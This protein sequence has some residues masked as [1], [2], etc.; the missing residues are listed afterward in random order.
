MTGSHAAAFGNAVRL[1]RDE[2]EHKRLV[3][4]VRT[5]PFANQRVAKQ[6][7]ADDQRTTAP[8]TTRSRLARRVLTRPAT[9]NVTESDG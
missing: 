6:T 7:L 8:A 5:L 1:A 9:T 3:E 2:N 4:A